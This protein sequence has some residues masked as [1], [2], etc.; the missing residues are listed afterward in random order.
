[1]K[2]R[3]LSLFVVMI[4]CFGISVPTI[5]ASAVTVNVELEV[6]YSAAY[7]ELELL[8]E[9]RRENGLNELVMDKDL[10]LMARQRAVECAV[11]Y[12]HTRPNGEKFST[13]LPIDDR[14]KGTFN[15]ENILYGTYVVGAEKATESWYDSPGH[16]A[17][18]L[19]PEFKSVGIACVKDVSGKSYWVQ[20]FSTAEGISEENPEEGREGRIFS[21]DVIEEFI[22]VHLDMSELHLQVGEEEL[23]YVRN[24][25][26]PIVPD[27]V[28]T[29]NEAVIQ[30]SPMAG[31]I[32]VT[33]VGGGTATLTLGFSGY[34]TKLTVVVEE[35]VEPIEL[36][37]LS[38]IEPE[39]GFLVQPGK[40]IYTTAL[41]LPQ[42]APE[43]PLI[44]ESE[45]SSIVSVSGRGNGCTITGVSP[46]TTTI[47][48]TTAEPVNG[49]VYTVSAEVTVYD[50]TSGPVPVA[51]NLSASYAELIPEQQLRLLAYVLPDT[52]NQSVTWSSND[53]SVA[54]VDQNGKVTAV[55]SGYANITCTASTEDVRAVCQIQ[56]KDS[57]FGIPITFTDVKKGDYF[58]D[59]VVWANSQQLEIGFA[60]SSFGVEKPC[61]RMNI[62]RY[63]WKLNGSP[64]PKDIDSNPFTDVSDLP[65][66]RDNYWAVQ[67]ALE[68]GV[69]SGT[70]ATTF[71]PSDTVTR[72]QAVTFLYRLAGEPSVAG[73]A[74]FDDVPAGNWFADAAVWAVK[75][76]ITQGT[77][78]NTFTPDRACTRAEI[79]TFLFREFS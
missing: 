41:F 77:G 45:D 36:E 21:V 7:E 74:G 5:A 61:T 15:G 66:N 52:A 3:I 27:I 59:A 9:I 18:M 24:D 48:A 40:N 69:T 50:K 49:Q 30:T 46:G 58:Y 73:N 57:V 79:L 70:S 51:V 32:V 63:L 4:L 71:S 8:N 17:N 64:Q 47:S 1:M 55:S 42:G 35:P 43:Y 68:T 31:G 6:D 11:Y 67:W 22:N 62:V 44:W 37:K 25:N 23:V 39:G 16:R 29:D 28:E 56:V 38:L 33:A 26:A 20:N 72:A 13:A 65:S 12:G 2:K 34:S 53:P 76:G 75:E 10:I 54:T 19:L 14:F 78:N 60:G